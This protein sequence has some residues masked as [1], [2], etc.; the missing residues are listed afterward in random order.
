M[1]GALTAITS[2]WG[3]LDPLGGHEG[4]QSSKRVVG[5]ELGICWCG[6]HCGGYDGVTSKWSLEKSETVDRVGM[7]QCSSGSDIYLLI[8]GGGVEGIVPW[9][10]NRGHSSK[11]AEA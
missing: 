10:T 3:T 1:L 2:R 6:F 5:L 11:S 9:E 4:S 7:R 8:L